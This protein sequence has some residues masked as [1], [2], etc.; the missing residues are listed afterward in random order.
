MLT[1]AADSVVSGT[2]SGGRTTHCRTLVRRITG[3]HLG[4]SRYLSWFDPGLSLV[5]RLLY[6]QTTGTVSYMSE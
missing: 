2:G 6:K 4:K 1:F 3:P 5:E